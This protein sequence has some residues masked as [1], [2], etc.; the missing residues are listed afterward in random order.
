MAE[1]PQ[2]TNPVA[3][4]LAVP[5]QALGRRPKPARPVRVVRSEQ[6]PTRIRRGVS[7]DGLKPAAAVAGWGL[8]VAAGPLLGA[9]AAYEQLQNWRQVAEL[10]QGGTHRG[11]PVPEYRDELRREQARREAQ[12]GRITAAATSKP[13]LWTYGGVGLVE[14]YAWSA[15]TPVAEAIATGTVCAGVL[16]GAVLWV[17]GAAYVQRLLHR[18]ARHDSA[19]IAAPV[20]A[21]ESE[22]EKPLVEPDVISKALVSAGIIKSDQT[23]TL[24]GPVQQVPGGWRASIVLPEGCTVGMVRAKI[25]RL[26]SA[27]TTTPAH[28]GILDGDSYNR[29]A[30][31]RYEVLPFTGPPVPHPLLGGGQVDVLHDGHPAGLDIDSQVARIDLARGRH[32]LIVASSGNGKT[33]H[34]LGLILTCAM[35]PTAEIVLCDGKPDGTL[36]P[37]VPLMADYVDTSMDKWSVKASDLLEAEVA[38]AEARRQRIRA[39]QNVGWRQI[40]LDEFQMFTGNASSGG[41]TQGS[42]R[43]RV[44]DALA[45]LSRLGRSAHV[46]LVL[47]TQSYD[48]NTIEEHVLNNIGWRIIGYAPS[49]VSREALG[50]HADRYG[51]D[52]ST[53]L[54]DAEQTGTAVIISP[55]IA[56]YAVARG[57]YQDKQAVQAA[58]QRALQ[59][60]REQEPTSESALSEEARALLAAC[61]KVYGNTDVQW[62]GT[63]ELRTE[64]CTRE[65]HWPRGEERVRAQQMRLANLLRE[66]RLETERSTRT[67]GVTA[68]S[69]TALLAAARRATHTTDSAA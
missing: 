28:L 4:L 40:I 43:R 64:V 11:D 42:S 12:L 21:L 67:G 1:R 55:G 51:L 59:G 62:I 56:R 39:G 6:Q 22:A 34:I 53:M 63:Q 35:D 37:V 45:E 32:G 5:G 14:L 8:A 23:A 33:Q 2:D 44:R 50:E 16:A 27:L 26:A 68:V 47:A 69:R 46:G 38:N 52:T 30:L 17:N 19:A 18:H 24:D 48:G 54:V 10:R 29:C 3:A 57:W 61:L 41:M 60:R 66:C 20:V 36:D 13:A 7:R 65:L 15:H 31:T 58:V 25:D 9:V 49:K